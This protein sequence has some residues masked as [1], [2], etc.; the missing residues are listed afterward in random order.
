MTADEKNKMLDDMKNAIALETDIATQRQLM[1]RCSKTMQEKCPVFV[2]LEEP[3]QPTPCERP[4]PNFLVFLGL[5]LLFLTFMK[6][7][8]ANFGF[9]IFS[10]IF[11]VLGGLISSLCYE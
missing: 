7:M 11:L 6:I 10:I 8:K 3:V 2:P 1:E 4:F 9:M 5:G